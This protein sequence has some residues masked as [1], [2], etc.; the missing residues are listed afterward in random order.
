MRIN[1]PNQITL[2]RLVLA[3]VF[4]ALLSQYSVAAGA[5]ADWILPTC[6][7]LFLIAALSD[8]LDGWLARAW[9]QVTP[10]GRV[11][12]PVVDKILVCGAFVFFAG[13]PFYDPGSGANTSGVAPWMVVLILLRELFVSA[14]RA[15]AEAGGRNFEANWI[16]K[17][18]MFVQSATACVILGVLSWF[19]RELH[20]LMI[21]CV[22]ATV[23]VTTLSIV[24]YA[25]RASTLL[26]SA[27][28]M[29]AARPAAPPEPTSEPV[30]ADPA[31][32]VPARQVSG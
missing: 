16:G 19:P 30:R 5:Q 9:R 27:D 29:G 13:G 17:A 21:A 22:W 6:F 15:F 14:V 4:F 23:A 11:L 28:A 20:A 26:F 31:L 12:D 7:W 25:R 32:T 1:V 8:V 10:F 3:I 18:K 2:V 24:S